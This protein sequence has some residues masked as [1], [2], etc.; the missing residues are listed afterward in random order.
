MTE[1]PS[2]DDIDKISRSILK[3]SHA[4]GIFPT[5]V[6]KIVNFTELVINKQIDISKVHE[7]YLQR[8][9]EALF[10]ALGKLRGLFDRSRKTIYLD[11]SQLP[12]RRNFVKLHET[13]HGVL[14][15]QQTIYEV[16]ED[17]DDSLSQNAIEEFEQEANYFASV[18]LFQHE[19]FFNELKKF[20]M[21][22][23]AAVA[24]SKR[25]GAS[26]HATLRK[27]IEHS[28]KRCALL[29]L[30]KA[31]PIKSISGF[32]KRNFFASARFL[33]TFGTI[34]WPEIFGLEWSFAKD[35]YSN[36]KGIIPGTVEIETGNGA[37]CLQYQF[38]NNH[39][40]GLVFLF[41]PGE[42]QSSK[43]DLILT[44]AR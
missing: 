1:L 37:E 17:D 21:G 15:W 44:S 8:A 26:L 41:P 28:P 12:T 20:H 24:L 6:D 42:K 2:A 7:G 19:I 33:A 30:D 36:R 13:G 10:R 34:E 43:I 39:Y 40:N 29:V 38:F 14:P 4:W 31:P 27:Y 16:L 32:P 9:P 22:I 3:G 5:P 35:Y 18:T 11:F 23:D 25:F